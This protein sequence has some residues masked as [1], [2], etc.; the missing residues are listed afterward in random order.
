M[1][2]QIKDLHEQ[3]KAIAVRVAQE[4]TDKAVEQTGGITEFIRKLQ[5]DPKQLHGSP[6]DDQKVAD[7]CQETVLQLHQAMVD[8]GYDSQA[9]NEYIKDTIRHW[10]VEA[11]VTHFTTKAEEILKRKLS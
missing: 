1:N 6:E 5:N 2:Q 11:G 4:R 7:Q 3:L 9:S 10:F 8:D